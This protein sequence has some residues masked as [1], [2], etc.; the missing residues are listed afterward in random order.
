MPR[1]L[2]DRQLCT[3]K[4]DADIQLVY[5][6]KNTNGDRRKAAGILGIS[7]RQVQR[8]IAHLN[9]QPRWKKIIDDI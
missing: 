2:F 1:N 9:Q 4:E 5:V 6:L 7:V 8:R 3:L